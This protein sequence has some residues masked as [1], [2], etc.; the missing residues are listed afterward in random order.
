MHLRILHRNFCTHFMKKN[1][2]SF[3]LAITIVSSL[4]ATQACNKGTS[5]STEKK[6][7]IINGSMNVDIPMLTG[8]GDN[9]SITSF[10]YKMNMDSFVK[11]YGSEYDTSS[12]R[13]VKLN[14]CVITLNDKDTANNIR[15]FH[16]T[17]I[18]ITSATNRNI[19][20]IAA[21]TDIVDTN[22][23]F[24]SIPKSYDPNLASYFKADSVRYRL[25][26]NVRRATTTE[27][28][29][30]ATISFDVVLTK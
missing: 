22:A 6:V 11:S 12:I 14:S 30:I 9:D 4:L 23:Y 25:Y 2:F 1:S 19:Y 15:N 29:G 10:Y 7:T 8:N 28:K 16:T 21:F 27:I 18:G 17:N 24:I 3:L 20:R 13:S 5:N 26:G